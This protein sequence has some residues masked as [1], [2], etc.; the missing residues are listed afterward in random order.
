MYT[1]VEVE[2]ARN[3][4]VCTT[5]SIEGKLV[6]ATAMKKGRQMVSDSNSAESNQ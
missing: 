2:K 6:N 3:A 1:N 5:T 4:E